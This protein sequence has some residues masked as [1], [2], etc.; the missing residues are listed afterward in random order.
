MATGFREALNS[1][2]V[3][4]FA[5]RGAGRLAPENT[6][7]AFAAAVSLGY[8]VLETD[9][10]VSR[11]G[12]PYVFHDA[13]LER[14]TGD[15]R[16][17]G[18]LSDADID[19]IRIGADHA[20]PRLDDL[21]ESFPEALFNLDAKTDATPAPMAAVINRH[22]AAGRVCIGS[23]SDARIRETLKHLPEGT[24]HSIGTANTIRFLLG[25]V[26]GLPLAFTADCAQLPL[27]WHGAPL[28]NARALAFA[29]R[30]GLRLHV[31][32]VN[33]ATEMR[34]LLALGVD[35]IMTDD[36]ALLRRVMTE[37]GLW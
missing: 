24:C 8:D 10:Q 3:L 21:L 20:I 2:R 19:S 1:G 25:Y 29:R 34:R 31:W 23:F 27:S 11:D 32:T 12:T 6:L 37:H 18:A 26:A 13:D 17:I 35:G 30:R 5:H 7:A 16:R 15:G 28:V 22:R 9:I 33:D 14:L 4:A 36:C